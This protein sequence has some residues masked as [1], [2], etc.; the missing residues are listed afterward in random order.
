LPSLSYFIDPIVFTGLNTASP[1]FE[2]SLKAVSKGFV[3][4]I[5]TSL[6]S[7]SYFNDPIVFTGLNTVW[8]ASDIPVIVV[9]N[10]FFSF[11]LIALKNR[12]ITNYLDFIK[13][14]NYIF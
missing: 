8:P 9:S 6:P 4:A 3:C 13:F 12:A 1:I 2:A 14:Y 11:A 7:L 10:P 5:L